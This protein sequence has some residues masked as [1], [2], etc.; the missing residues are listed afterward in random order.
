MKE[1][2]QIHGKIVVGEHD[3]KDFKPNIPDQTTKEY[4]VRVYT[5]FKFYIDKVQENELREFA[6][7]GQEWSKSKS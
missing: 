3:S 1:Y 4:F 6:I 7:C 2:I 5:I